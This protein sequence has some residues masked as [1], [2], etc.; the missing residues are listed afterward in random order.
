MPDLEDGGPDTTEAYD[1]LLWVAL[2]DTAGS[3]VNELL[4]VDNS[5]RHCE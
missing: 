2:F 3:P 5:Y 4:I 1:G